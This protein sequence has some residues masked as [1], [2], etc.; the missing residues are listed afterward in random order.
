MQRGLQD[1]APEVPGKVID[2]PKLPKGSKGLQRS[3]QRD[4]RIFAIQKQNES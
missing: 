4:G 1:T 2:R 3:L